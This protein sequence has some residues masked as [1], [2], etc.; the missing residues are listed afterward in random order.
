[1]L[2][3]ALHAMIDFPLR[4]P[5]IG[6]LAA[7]WAGIWAGSRIPRNAGARPAAGKERLP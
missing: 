2:A 7:A 1:L 5:W 6:M 3:C 4:N